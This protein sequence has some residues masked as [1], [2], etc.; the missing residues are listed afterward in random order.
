EDIIKEKGLAQVSDDSALEAVVDEV[1]QENEAVANQIREG[2]DS[3][4]GFMVGQAMKKTQGK[5]NPK[6]VGELI[7]RRLSNG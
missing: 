3:A 6:K 4:V 2:K 7:K 1:I 5:A